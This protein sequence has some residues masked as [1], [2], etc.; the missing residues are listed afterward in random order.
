MKFDSPQFVVEIIGGK[1]MFEPR[2]PPN[3]EISKEAAKKLLE[4]I[5]TMRAMQQTLNDKDDL[6]M[7]ENKVKA[8]LDECNEEK[9]QEILQESVENAI[10]CVNDG[11]KT[12]QLL[13]TLENCDSFWNLSVNGYDAAGSPIV[14]KE[15]VVIIQHL[16]QGHKSILSI[17][18]TLKS[19]AEKALK[20]SCIKKFE[21][22]R[23]HPDFSKMADKQVNDLGGF[24][25]EE[26]MNSKI[27]AEG[28]KKGI[29]LHIEPEMTA[30]PWVDATI[31]NPATGEV[32]CVQYKNTTKVDNAYNEWK[33]TH[34]IPGRNLNPADAK[35]LDNVEVIVRKGSAQNASQQ[36]RSSGNQPGINDEFKFGEIKVDPPSSDEMKTFLK[37]NYPRMKKLAEL[38]KDRQNMV[39]ERKTAIKKIDK[40][41]ESVGKLKQKIQNMQD[42]VTA[43]KMKKNL[44][45]KKD[46]L[47]DIKASLVDIEIKLKSKNKKMDQVAKEDG[48]PIWNE[49]DKQLKKE[50]KQAV[51]LAAV[52]SAGTEL[53][54]SLVEEI[55]DWNDGKITFGKM[56]GNVVKR[57][58]TQCAIGTAFGGKGLFYLKCS[59]K[60]LNS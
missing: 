41:K 59:Y 46:K 32:K 55:Q 42:E 14:K 40:M 31:T 18:S 2:Q 20:E 57:T 24:T 7:L 56:V 51:L 49:V 6:E 21:I 4:D 48:G 33:T 35:Y 3:I 5:N 44:D 25:F 36:N 60:Y 34:S 9:N 16:V 26:L 23:Q 38:S 11:L 30:T 28:L 15:Y 50:A 47:E 29:S 43:A 37:E 8:S 1:K 45:I 58:A 54:I 19:G 12:S 52:I 53:I 10:E 39:N 22:V 13:D 27:I 17:H